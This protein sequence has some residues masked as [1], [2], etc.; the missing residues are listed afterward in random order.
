MYHSNIVKISRSSADI[1]LITVPACNMQALLT[2][3]LHLCVL[4][5]TFSAKSSPKT[6]VKT[7][8]NII[9]VTL[10]SMSKENGTETHQTGPYHMT[11]NASK[12]H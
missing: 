2:P 10:L 8:A 9:A 12:C 6:I 3:A 7:T 1:S 5:L 11:T 4:F